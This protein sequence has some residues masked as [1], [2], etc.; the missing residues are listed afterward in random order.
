MFK[1]FILFLF[2]PLIGIQSVKAT[3]IYVKVTSTS[4]LIPGAKYI[5]AATESGTPYVATGYNYEGYLA[6]TSSGCSIS[7][8]G[9]V[10]TISTANPIVFT[11]GGNSSGYTLKDNLTAKYLGY[12]TGTS[13]RES[14]TDTDSS[15]KW[16]YTYNNTSSSFL[17]KN[18]GED[19]RMLFGRTFGTKPNEYYAFRANTTAAITNKLAPANLYRKVSAVTLASACTDGVKYYGTYSNE[20]AFVVPSDLTVSEIKVTDGKLTVGNYSTGDVV[21]ANTGVMISSST[22]GDHS[23]TLTSAAGSSVFGSENMLRPT[24]SGI[25]AEAMAAADGGCKYYR[26]TMH[27][28]TALG[29]YWGAADGAAFALGANKAY[30]AV[31]TASARLT[32]FDMADS[33]TTDIRVKGI[34]NSERQR[35]GDGTSGMEFAAVAVYDLQGRRVADSSLK[36]GLYIVNGKKYIIK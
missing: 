32:G 6:T 25:T 9:N 29:Y 16:T 24:G 27:N 15:E 17:L 33:E 23:V 1:R 22:A 31:P 11:L 28:G 10:I 12:G 30:L 2:L 3:D 14:E 4:D 19:T 18:V 8:D 35:V 20:S 36:K 34:V 7:I 5:L 26:L 13:L 21:P